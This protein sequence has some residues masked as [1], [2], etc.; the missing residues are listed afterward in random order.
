MMTATDLT[1]QLRED[2]ADNRSKG[3][4]LRAVRQFVMDANRTSD[5]VQLLEVDPGSTGDVRWDALVAGVVE[6]IAFRRNSKVPSWTGHPNRFLATWWFVTDFHRLHPTAFVET[7]A[8]IANR[9]VF[10]RRSSLENV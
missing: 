6:N 2:L 3:D 7:P 4:M 10:L 5:V 8:A 1:V 9:G